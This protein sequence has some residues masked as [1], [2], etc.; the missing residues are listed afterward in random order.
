MGQAN[1]IACG[2]H[3][4][5]P[6]FRRKLLAGLQVNSESYWMHLADVT[7]MLGDVCFSNRPFRVKRFQTYAPLQR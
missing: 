2:K 5:W 6:R 3:E 4:D 7:T 1:Q